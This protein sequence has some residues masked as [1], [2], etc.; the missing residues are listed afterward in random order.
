MPTQNKLPKNLFLS[1]VVAAIAFGTTPALVSTPLSSV[2]HAADTM[3]I[4]AIPPKLELK[5]DPGQTVT[6]T[7]KVRND[8]TE[9]QNYAVTVEDFVVIDNQGT[10]VPVTSKTGNRWSLQNWI[11]APKAIPVDAGSVQTINLSI[12]IPLTALPGGHYAMVTYTPNADIKS[13]DLK[14]TGNVITQRVGTLLYVTVNGP[15]TEKANI[16]SFSAPDFTEQGPVNFT[17]TVESLS[18]SHINP[19]GSISIYNPINTKVADINIDAGNVFPETSRDFTAAWNQKWGWGRYRADLSLAYGAAGTLLTASAF[20][21]FFPIR[22]VIYI[23]TGLIAILSIILVLNK[24]SQK[25]Q[26]EL[27]K[28]VQQL[29][30]ELES[31][32]NKTSNI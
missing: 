11:T 16:T 18:D 32:E 14:V 19:K 5:G 24:R 7:L 20:F 31:T 2:A 29:K 15:I 10:P 17:G 28:E 25:H 21:W 9:T 8:T 27:E 4:T 3:T 1:V 22:L 23:L 12:K 13:G 6:A 26:Q 30:E